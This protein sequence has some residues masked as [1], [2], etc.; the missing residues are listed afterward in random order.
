MQARIDGA[1]DLV[2]LKV[3]AIV[4]GPNQ[5]IE[6]ARRATSTVP[7]VMV[8]GSDP[9]GRGYITSLARPGGNI[10]GLTWDAA[11]EIFGKYVELLAELSPRPSRI[12]GV[13]DPTSSD[14]ERYWKEAAI[15]AKSHGLTLQYVELRAST[16]LPKAFDTIVRERAGA[17]IVFPGLAL[18]SYRG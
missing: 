6:V 12:A 8:Y 16:D 3:E 15:A 4:T 14:Y 5:F 10:T 11:P 1:A 13:V 2:H 9:V 7:I 17:V 18:W